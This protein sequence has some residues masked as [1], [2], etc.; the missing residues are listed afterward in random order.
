MIYNACATYSCNMHVISAQYC[1]GWGQVAS[2]A[3]NET[4]ERE[5]QA[6]KRH[7]TEKVVEMERKRRVELLLRQRK[8]EKIDGDREEKPGEEMEVIRLG[9]RC[10]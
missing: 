8:R 10:S 1:I 6:R 2:N 4:M 5:H 9:T 3:R 7:V